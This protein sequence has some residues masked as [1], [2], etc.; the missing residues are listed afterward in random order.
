VATSQ[1]REK[2][3]VLTLKDGLANAGHDPH[4]DGD[5]GRVGELHTNLGEG[6]S[7]GA[8]GEGNDV[9]GPALH[10]AV[11][12]LVHLGPHLVGSH[13]VVRG[14]GIILLLRANEGG[15]LGSVG[16]Q[17]TTPQKWNEEGE[18]N[19]EKVWK[20]T[21]YLATSPG[22]VLPR[23]ELGRFFWL[24][25]SMVPPLMSCSQSSSYSSWEPERIRTFLGLKSFWFS[26]THLMSFLLVVT[27]LMLVLP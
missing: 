27:S 26:S 7:N 18:S 15:G 11:I 1:K 3:T 13:P 4:V 8:H 5:E 19:E 24:S 6:G 12:E 10:G 23:K 25:L 16:E 22:S 21:Q 14:A 20:D 2:G 9:H 17:R